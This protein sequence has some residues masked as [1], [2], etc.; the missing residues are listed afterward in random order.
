MSK[1]ILVISNF[2]FKKYGGAKTIANYLVNGYKKD[3]YEVKTVS[4]PQISGNFVKVFSQFFDIIN[5]LAVLKIKKILK[6]EKPD[7]VHFHNIHKDISAYSVKA[8]KKMGVPVIITL[9]DFW[10]LC[11]GFNLENDNECEM[12]CRK[13]LS[14]FEINL[15]FRNLLISKLLM[16][17]DYIFLPSNF[18]CERF[19][20][21][22]YSQEKAK[23][24]YNGIDLN[25]FRLTENK[26]ENKKVKIIFVG[27]PTKKKGVEFLKESIKDL[28]NIEL[29]VVGGDDAV[30]YEDLPKVY[31]SVDICVQPSLVHETFGLTI[32]EAMACGLPVVITKMGGMPE[33]IGEGGIKVEA[34]DT[35]KL[36]LVLK[37]LAQDKNKREKLGLMGRK[38]AGR[39][40]KEKMIKE[41]LKYI[42]ELC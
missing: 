33:L 20:E 19:L 37:E 25:K 12:V 24:I 5:P 17:A 13:P 32:V 38:E 9:H 30:N 14:R 39:F 27:R 1:K 26:P 35:Q 36:S 42:K 22:G 34:W 16:C 40:D 11:S 18:A 31:Q 4:I 6:T 28:E 23:R 7:L 15:P 10:A 21:R 2:S 3:G 29:E 8:I 41:Y